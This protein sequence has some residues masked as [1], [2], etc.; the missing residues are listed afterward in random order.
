[1]FVCAYVCAYAC[2]LLCV[3]ACNG[4]YL[5]ILGYLSIYLSIYL[6]MCPDVR[7]SFFLDQLRYFLVTVHFI[8]LSIYLCA[9][10]ALLRSLIQEVS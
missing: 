2:V 4:T 1:M 6:S 3:Y 5:A 8:Y 10:R 7:N 9:I